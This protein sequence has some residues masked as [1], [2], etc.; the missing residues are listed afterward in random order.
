[1]YSSCPIHTPPRQTR[2]RP[3]CFV[4]FGGRC[5]YWVLEVLKNRTTS[6]CE[7][8]R[9]FANFSRVKLNR[10]RTPEAVPERTLILIKAVHQKLSISINQSI[11]LFRVVQVTKSL[12]G[13]LEVGNSLLGISDNVRE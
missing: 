4:V 12:Q 3:D 11:M 9:R 1:M 6:E 8:F 10:D 13:P 7:K 2:H 5:D